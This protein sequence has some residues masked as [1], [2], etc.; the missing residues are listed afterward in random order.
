[1]SETSKS[2]GRSFGVPFW[3]GYLASSVGWFVLLAGRHL[4]GGNPA[5]WLDV[6]LVCIGFGAVAPF[7]GVVLQAAHDLFLAAWR[8]QLRFWHFALLL[9]L[10]AAFLVAG[11]IN[12]LYGSGST[13]WFPW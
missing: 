4:L 8:G 2:P 5:F 10:I 3:I 12:Y 11:Y 13:P 9:A 6:L 7:G 1:M